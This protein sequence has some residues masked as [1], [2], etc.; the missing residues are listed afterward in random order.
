[1]NAIEVMDL[2][3]LSN[4][5]KKTRNCVARAWLKQKEGFPPC[6]PVLL[7]SVYANASHFDR[8]KMWAEFG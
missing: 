1:M 2:L 3:I 7:L 5:N 8:L 4:I 6:L